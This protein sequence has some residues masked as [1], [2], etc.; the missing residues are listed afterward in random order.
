[1]N[2]WVSEWMK[3]NGQTIQATN[4]TIKHMGRENKQKSCVRLTETQRRSNRHST[5]IKTSRQTGRPSKKFPAFHYKTRVY[6][7]ITMLWG[8]KC[9]DET[10]LRTHSNVEMCVSSHYAI[11]RKH[12]QCNR[13]EIKKKKCNTFAWH[14][15][16]HV[17]P[18][19]LIYSI[20][21]M[22]PYIT[23][24]LHIQCTAMCSRHKKNGWRWQISWEFIVYHCAS[25]VDHTVVGF[26]QWSCNIL[27]V[28][29]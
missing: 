28:S 22:P 24:K 9:D 18:F 21:Q 7:K 2:G 20:L 6:C 17:H 13:R 1:M 19:A 25:C 16:R 14:D 12:M 10:A 5:Q 3:K 26:Y 29:T 27:S 8:L 11:R 4:D 23:L 15:W